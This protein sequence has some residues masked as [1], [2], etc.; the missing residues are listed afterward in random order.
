MFMIMDLSMKSK[1]KKKILMIKFKKFKFSLLRIKKMILKDLI[2]KQLKELKKN[3]KMI[4]N[5]KI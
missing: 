4:R 1:K 3:K 2:A 5:I